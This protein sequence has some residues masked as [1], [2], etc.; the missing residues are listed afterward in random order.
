MMQTGQTI[1]VKGKQ[2]QKQAAKGWRQT[3]VE[4]SGSRPR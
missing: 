4:M 3:E 2:V 1:T